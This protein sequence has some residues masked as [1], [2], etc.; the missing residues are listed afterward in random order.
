[1]SFQ[2]LGPLPLRFVQASI[3]SFSW[4]VSSVPARC[5]GS[6]RDHPSVARSGATLIVVFMQ[7]SACFAC[8][9]CA[10]R[11]RLVPLWCHARFA[12]GSR[13]HWGNG[14]TKDVYAG[15]FVALY[16]ILLNTFPLLFSANAPYRLNLLG[17]T[18]PARFDGSATGD[19]E[20]DSTDDN[21]LVVKKTARLSSAAQAHQTRSARW[22]SIVAGAI[23]GGVAISFESLSRRKVIAQQ[24][25]VR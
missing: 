13:F 16:R 19:S 2:E 11:N 21:L 24:L 23:A 18:S 15:S 20:P 7:E 6:S 14:L 1:M 5:L 25:F 4:H 8:A 10:L 9:T 22:H 12:S 17:S 3:S